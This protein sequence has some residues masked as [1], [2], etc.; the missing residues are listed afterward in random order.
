MTRVKRTKSWAKVGVGDAWLD[1]HARHGRIVA[2]YGVH[3]Q[4]G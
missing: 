1:G 4:G 3:A 2:D